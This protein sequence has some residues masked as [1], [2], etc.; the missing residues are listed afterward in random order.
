MKKA[1]NLSHRRSRH[2]TNNQQWST[3]QNF[4]T[5]FRRRRFIA[6]SLRGRPD[7]AFAAL[8]QVDTPILFIAGAEDSGVARI[9][10][11]TGNL[12]SAW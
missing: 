1:R 4:D 9:N 3:T 10:Q 5:D 7:L 8:P 6:I 12:L 2:P 11:R